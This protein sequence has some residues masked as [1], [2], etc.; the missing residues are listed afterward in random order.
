[1]SIRIHPDAE[2][3]EVQAHNIRV[4]PRADE[5]SEAGREEGLIKGHPSPEVE[6]HSLRVHPRETADQQSEVEA[7]HLTT[8]HGPAQTPEAESR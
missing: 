8:G 5:S 3:P 4:H 1:M 2:Q 7:H 6:S